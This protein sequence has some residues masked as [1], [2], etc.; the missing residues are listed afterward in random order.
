MRVLVIIN[1]SFTP[2]SANFLMMMCGCKSTVSTKA[3][4]GDV[5]CNVSGVGVKGV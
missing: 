4:R 2:P 3:I 5:K 1:A